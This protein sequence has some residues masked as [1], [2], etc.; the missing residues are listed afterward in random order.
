MKTQVTSLFDIPC[1]V[2]NIQANP[3]VRSIYLSPAFVGT[4]YPPNP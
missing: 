4:W 1:S 2:F 3:R